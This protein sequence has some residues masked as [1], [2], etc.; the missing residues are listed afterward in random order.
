MHFSINEEESICFKYLKNKT[1]PHFPVSMHRVKNSKPY[2]DTTCMFTKH[3]VSITTL[4]KYVFIHIYNN[5]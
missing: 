3:L 2:W 1:E 5:I 4:L